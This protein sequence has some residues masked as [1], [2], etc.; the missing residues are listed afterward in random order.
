MWVLTHLKEEVWRYKTM[1]ASRRQT[2]PISFTTSTNFTITQAVLT[3]KVN[4]DSKF[5]D[6]VGCDRYA[7]VSY[8]GFQFG[9]DDTVLNQSNLAIS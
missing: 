8:S 3:V 7:G 1:A 4:D 9:E 2:T 5:V 6:S